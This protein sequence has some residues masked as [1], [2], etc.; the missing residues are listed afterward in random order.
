MGLPKKVAKLGLQ[1]CIG[2]LESVQDQPFV[3]CAMCG[4]IDFEYKA[5]DACRCLREGG[6]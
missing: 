1:N 6:K 4:G 5:G 3:R 2:K